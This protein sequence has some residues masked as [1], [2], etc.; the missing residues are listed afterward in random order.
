M[1][2][3]HAALAT[4]ILIETGLFFCFQTTVPAVTVQEIKDGELAR[5]LSGTRVALV[6]DLHM[7]GS[8][9]PRRQLEGP[10]A[11]INPD[12]V[13][14]A[15]DLVAGNKGITACVEL[16]GRIARDRRVIAIL[17]NND[18]SYGNRRMDTEGLVRGLETVGVT[19]LVNESVK[20]E[21]GASR[22]EGCV[23]VAGVDDNFLM[24]DDLFKARENI[25]SEHPMILLAHAPQIVE[26][27][28]TEGINLVLSGHTHGGQIVLPF[29]GALYTN[30]VYRSRKKFVAGLYDEGT[31][32]Y[33]SRGI[34]TSGVPL[35]FMCRPEITVFSFV[36]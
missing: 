17:G 15:G 31:K 33:V 2:R 34:G 7:K 36:E 18:H 11:R 1:K 29:L 4:A 21:T 23:Y 12:I 16:L 25:P 27:V 8:G 5:A 10:I 35:R 19:V 30:P 24:Y 20:L 14:V 32:V 9:M 13:F 3:L 22:G 26:K 6:S 28:E